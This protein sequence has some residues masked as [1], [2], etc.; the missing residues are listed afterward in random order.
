MAIPYVYFEPCHPGS[1]LWEPSGSRRYRCALCGAEGY[2]KR[3]PRKRGGQVMWL[4]STETVAYLCR[5]CKGPT[6]KQGALCP[7]CRTRVRF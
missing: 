4:P 2:R 6:K 3:A 7:N 5:A 1:H